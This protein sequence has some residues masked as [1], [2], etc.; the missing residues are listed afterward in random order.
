MD[1]QYMVDFNVELIQLW[2]GNN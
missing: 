1:I 2:S